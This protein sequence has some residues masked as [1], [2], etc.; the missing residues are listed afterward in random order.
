MYIERTK[1]SICL[2]K[3]V[4][5]KYDLNKAKRF[6]YGRGIYSS[7]YPSIAEGYADAFTFEN[8]QYKVIIQNKVNM[9]GTDHIKSVNYFLTKEEKDIRPYALLYKKV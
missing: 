9:K 4:Y 1:H 2:S 8:K 6:S 7:P 3:Q 5:I